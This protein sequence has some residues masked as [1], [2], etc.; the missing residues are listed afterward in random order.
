MLRRP[1][2]S[3]RTDTLC[4]YTT[5]VRSG[6]TLVADGVLAGKVG[7]IRGDIINDGEVIFDQSDDATYA[8][9][10]AGSGQ[11]SKAGTGVLTLSGD[12]GL[13]WM[14]KVGGLVSEI[15]RAHV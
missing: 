6:G 4:P 11:M 13:D 14:V 10:I 9:A 1:P 5:L 2:R 12:S 15:G 8:G 3:T 7:S